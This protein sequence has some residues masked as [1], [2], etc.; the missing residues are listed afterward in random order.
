MKIIGFTGKAGS[1]KATR[2]TELERLGWRRMSFADPIRA[3]LQAWLNISVEAGGTEAAADLQDAKQYAEL[4]E[5][6]MAMWGEKTLRQM[7]QL[8]GTEFGRDKVDPDTWVKTM[9]LRIASLEH[10]HGKSRKADEL[11]IVIDDV[12]FENE[13]EMIRSLGGTVIRLVGPEGPA[14]GIEGHRSEKG[15][16]DSLVDYTVRW[17]LNFDTTELG[18]E[19]VEMLGQLEKAC[20]KTR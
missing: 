15:L 1:G 17:G 2:A 6:P 4:K 16:P 14:T 7:M 18:R 12:R 5:L 19:I 20:G 11:R 13:A 8:L 10:G 3:M 9:R